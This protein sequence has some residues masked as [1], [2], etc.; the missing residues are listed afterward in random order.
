M[1]DILERLRP[2]ANYVGL[3]KPHCQT[4][5][6]AADEIG[7]LRCALDKIVKISSSRMVTEIARAALAASAL[8]SQDRT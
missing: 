1:T 5:L 7:Q 3:Y 6:E 2:I 4:I 8:P